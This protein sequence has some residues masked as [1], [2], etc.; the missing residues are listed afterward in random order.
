MKEPK[1]RPDNS[2]SSSASNKNASA[3]KSKKKIAKNEKPSLSLKPKNEPPN[4]PK[5]S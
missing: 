4:K 5:K 1:R 3:T 2:R